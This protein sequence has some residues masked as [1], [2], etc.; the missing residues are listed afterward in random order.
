L[1][2]VDKC[3]QHLFPG[4][5]RLFIK[6]DYRAT[7]AARIAA[8]TPTAGPAPAAAG[9]GVGV[10]ASPEVVL[11]V[12]GVTE[13]TVCRLLVTAGLLAVVLV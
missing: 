8:T 5:I 3:Q 9:S 13:E 4:H 2:K 6:T 10:P 11:K 7:R 1:S 12:G